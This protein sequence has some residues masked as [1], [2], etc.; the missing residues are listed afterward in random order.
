MRQP[1]ELIPKIP[2][3]TRATR[4]LS[5]R[6]IIA[7]MGSGKRMVGNVL[8]LIVFALALAF[9]V[10]AAIAVSLMGVAVYVGALLAVWLLFA[11]VLPMLTGVMAPS[12]VVAN[13][14]SRRNRRSHHEGERLP[15]WNVLWLE[16]LLK[17]PREYQQAPATRADFSESR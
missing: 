14:R 17:K 7:A 15:D 13:I 10:I 6:A 2:A 9:L 16:T 8:I 11:Y 4:S 12:E 3:R 5:E 1:A